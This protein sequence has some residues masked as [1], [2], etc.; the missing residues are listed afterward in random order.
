MWLGRGY[1]NG[2]HVIGTSKG[3]TLARSIRRLPEGERFELNVIQH[4]KGKP[5]SPQEDNKVGVLV[6]LPPTLGPEDIPGYLV[7]S[8]VQTLQ[9]FW[10]S[11]GKT[12]ACRACN[13]V[14]LEYITQ[15]NADDGRR[16]AARRSQK[17]QQ[18]LQQ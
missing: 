11:E 12:P 10:A 8:S 2:E 13:L 17:Q 6:Q 14:D 15:L 18:Q 3:T 4:M 1:R 7:R 5:W 16:P 9:S